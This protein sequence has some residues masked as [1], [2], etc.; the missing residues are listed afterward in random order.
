MNRW[1]RGETGM[2]TCIMLISPGNL[3][4]T[5][6]S[7]GKAKKKREKLTLRISHFNLKRWGA[8][9]Q[10]SI[11]IDGPGASSSWYHCTVTVSLFRTSFRLVCMSDG[12]AG[13]VYSVGLCCVVP[14]GLWE[15]GGCAAG[16]VEEGNRRGRSS[17]Y[18]EPTRTMWTPGPTQAALSPL[19]SGGRLATRTAVP[20]FGAL[21]RGRR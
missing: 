14:A 10:T 1:Q 6:Q 5:K 11:Q 9:N 15:S 21:G 19:L 7:T 3:K 20:Q 12:E 13:H 8:K 16:A 4:K 18:R 17:A 2:Y